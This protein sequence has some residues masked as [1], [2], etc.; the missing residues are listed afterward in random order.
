MSRHMDRDKLAK[1]SRRNGATWRVRELVGRDSE[2][3]E[4]R[5]ARRLRP[6]SEFE[7]LNVARVVGSGQASP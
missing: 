2:K 3:L 6:N 7:L 4:P 5:L 1:Q